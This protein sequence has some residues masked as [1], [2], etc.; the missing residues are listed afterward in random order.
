MEQLVNTTA[1]GVIK[2]DGA[3]NWNLWKFQ[4]SV[5][6]RNLEVYD[7]V[8][9]TEIQPDKEA[10]KAAWIKKD[11]KA[12]SLIVTRLSEKAML[13]IVTC[14]TA[15][16]MWKRLLGVYEQTTET[17]VHMTQQQFYALNCDGEDILTFISKVEELRN[18]LKEMGEE[19]SE[20]FAIA[21]IIMSLPDCYKH[22]ASAWESTESNKQTLENLIARLIVEQER[23]KG[24]KNTEEKSVALVSRNVK[25]Y[26]CE[27]P[28]HLAKF[29]RNK[30]E[31]GS[32]NNLCFYCKKPG[33]FKKDCYFRNADVNKNKGSN[34]LC[35]IE[36]VINEQSQNISKWLV[37]SGA[38]EHMSF[39]RTLFIDYRE[40]SKPKEILLGDGRIIN[41]IG[42]GNM[43][44]K[45]YNGQKWIDTSLSNVL[46]VPNLTVNLLSV[47]SAVNKGYVIQTDS[48]QCKFIKNGKTGAVANLEGKLFVL[49][50]LRCHKESEMAVPMLPI[51][52]INVWHAR[53][54]HQN[55]EKVMTILKHNNIKYSGSKESCVA[56][57]QGKQHRLPF[58]KSITETN[59]TCQLIHADVC[60]PMEETSIGG[61]RYF[62]LLKDD[63]SNYRV[64]YFMKNK[65]QTVDYVRKF[66]ELSEKETGNNI[67]TIRTDNGR[68]FINKEMK[69]LLERK[70]IRHETTVTYTP[71]QN[72]K[73][74]RD[75]RTIVEGARTQLL[76]KGLNKDL[77]A[78]SVNAVIYVLNRTSDGRTERKTAFEIWTRKK[79][80]I[81]SLHT[82]GS[83]VYVHIPKQLRRKWDAKSE[84][85]IFVGYGETV[86]G[87][88]VYFPEQKSVEIK[89]DVVFIETDKSSKIILSEPT[90]ESV[91]E[92]ITQFEENEEERENTQSIDN[93]QEEGES[94]QSIENQE[95]EGE[96]IQSDHRRKRAIKP[97]TWLED[98][99]TSFMCI[100]NE[101]ST[102]KEAMDRE[103]AEEWKN[104]IDSEMSAL[105][106]NET[107]SIVKSVPSDQKIIN[108]KWVFKCKRND[109]ELKY[110]ARLVARGFEQKCSDIFDLYAPVAKLSTFRVFMS[111]ATQLTL[112]VYQMDVCSAFL[113]ST[114]KENVYMRLPEGAYPKSNVICKLNKSIYGL[115]RA[116]KY[117]N[118]RFDEVMLHN[119]FVR[120]ENDSCLYVKV[121]KD[122]KTYLLLYVDDILYFSSCNMEL[123]RLK[124]ILFDNFKMK[125]MGKVT[126][127]LGIN[128]KQDCEKGI[129]VI[130]QKD[131]LNN[132][133]TL[134]GMSDCKPSLMPIDHNFKFEMLKRDRSESKE[135]E[136]KCRSLI[137]CL[138]FA[139]MG[140]RPD[141][142]SIVI[143]LS[144]YQTY[145][146][147]MLFTVL[148]RVLRYIKGTLD[149]SLIY[150][151]NKDNLIQ[152]YVD[153]DWGSCILDRKSTTGYC[154]K[155]FD[156]TV[157]W[158][159]KKQHTVAIST[160]ESEYIALATATSEACWLRKLIIDFN[161]MKDLTAILYED[162]QSAIKISVNP[163]NNKRI[164]H[165]DIKHY[166]IKEKLDKGVIDI[167]YICTNDQLAD[168]FTKV[169]KSNLFIKFRD[170][171]LSVNE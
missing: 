83:E 60:G 126:K 80:N 122:S 149:L 124:S 42:T 61:S 73:A 107:W 28:G 81:N 19:I 5:L 97:P 41:A 154:F 135:I 4:V 123:K 54:G 44:L 27:K 120:S 64:A 117:W 128:V 55:F 7:V 34:A 21:K 115:K 9:G 93:F 22:F 62:L 112:T 77:W 11:V 87:F 108:S 12:Q 71:E 69:I 86:K 24:H 88:R 6:L 129:T 56:C 111:V 121:C 168:I 53:L 33:H 75:M 101:P 133:L 84:R 110:K 106:E 79:F 78:E 139:V 85:G 32:K 138:M 68:E 63:Y 45:A 116:P 1:V 29:C 167:K 8:I 163:G 100:E 102:Y 140:T 70:G 155:V 48:K 105:C 146:S 26:K 35:V 2:L 66:I 119:Y 52:N 157:M 46:F 148:K 156:C 136:S 92:E 131:Y 51:E 159:T 169:L 171:M 98:Y 91:L 145:A 38:S 65:S 142:C 90:S 18:K 40:L 13:H 170:K 150:K 58:S 89:R 39:E 36:K 82:F 47:T 76:A 114:L 67:Q 72:G 153:S 16:G 57:L 109:N 143:I 94:V 20:K 17:S 15:A 10:D 160:T 132:L 30:K 50:M 96:N 137:G 95:E 59:K 165:I 125:D 99:E 49:N 147:S 74:E 23:I 164:K 43:Q 130:N 37:D 3:R 127:Y 31:T 151:C 118:N 104:A 158:G 161:I 162:N 144:R 134:F 14:S 166:F 141:L 152:G 25:C 113:N 103:D